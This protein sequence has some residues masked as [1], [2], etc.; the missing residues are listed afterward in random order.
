[1]DKKKSLASFKIFDDPNR[2]VA[3]EKGSLTYT[4][5]KDCP[6]CGSHI[7][8]VK[9]YACHPCE[10]RK[11]KDHY[12]RPE[13][14]ARYKEHKLKKYGITGHQYDEML[15]EQQDRCAICGIHTD[16]HSRSFAVDH[17]HKSG[18][19][20]GLLCGKCNTAL[21]GIEYFID[22]DNQ[23]TER[24]LIQHAFSYMRKATLNDIQKT[25]R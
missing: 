12:S 8:Y 10:L 5:I 19:I 23:I 25:K 22:N 21:Y 24:P 14:K 13:S 9:S 3:I 18:S 16:E 20:R 1:M 4:S 6:K 11:Q 17:D 7:R 15:N 2:T